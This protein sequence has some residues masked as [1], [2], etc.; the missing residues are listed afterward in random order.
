MNFETF[1]KTVYD[2]Y[3]T[4]KRSFPWRDEVTP[5]R[6][7]ISEVMLQQTQAGGRTIEKFNAFI[8]R[9]PDFNTLAAAPLSDILKLWQGLGYNRRALMLKR[10]AEIIVREY[11]GKLPS[12]V[13]ELDALPGIGHATACSISAFA[14]NKPVI[15]IETNIRSVFIHHFFPGRGGVS[16]KELLPIVASTLDTENAREWYSA[17]MDYGSTLKKKVGNESRRSKHY[18]KQ[19]TFEGSD[20][21][22]R[23]E[24]LRLVSA[25]GTVA[26]EGLHLCNA[27]AV[28]MHTVIEGLIKE[29]L[30]VRERGSI[31]IT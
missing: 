3:N 2:Y 17:L 24:L 25:Q 22:I 16:D 23:G 15:F 12:T 31:R 28:R 26:C 30:I 27:D 8:E 7:F 6:V 13:E 18:A 14:F 9:F 1:R 20:R 5:Y 19:S 4:N 29:G 11:D 21:Q 10:A